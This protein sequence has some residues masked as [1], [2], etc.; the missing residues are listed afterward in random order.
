M[1]ELACKEVVF[2]FNK[3]HLKD[4]TIPMWVLKARGQTFYVNHVICELPWSTKE[5][6]ANRHTKGSI[7]VKQALLTIDHNNE[8]RLSVL[9]PEDQQRLAHKK[10]PTRIGW[11]YHNN[12]LVQQTLHSMGA[13]HTKIIWLS[14]GCTTGWYVCDVFDADLVV[15]LKLTV[16]HG[17]REFVSNEWQFKDYDLEVQNADDEALAVTN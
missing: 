11:T 7:K 17:F 6:P 5:S 9:T 10:Q 12:P 3:A 4:P 15:Q 14:T 13:S 16:S 1:T 8:A 2:H